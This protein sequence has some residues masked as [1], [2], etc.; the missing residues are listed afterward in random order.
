MK[1]K[2]DKILAD[3]DKNG[4]EKDFTGVAFV[5]MKKETWAKEMIHKQEKSFFAHQLLKW[6]VNWECCHPPAKA[7][8][9]GKN[10]IKIKRAPEPSDVYWENVGT[11]RRD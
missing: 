7:L 2:I 6:Q 10:V 3:A 9:I 5:T 1:A 4:L 11:R 8:T